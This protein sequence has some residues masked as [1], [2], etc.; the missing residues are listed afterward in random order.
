MVPLMVLANLL[1]KLFLIKVA[2]IL[3]GKLKFVKLALI[4]M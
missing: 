1:S 2:K 3:I 4:N